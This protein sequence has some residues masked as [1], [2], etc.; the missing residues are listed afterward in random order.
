MDHVGVQERERLKRE[1]GAFLNAMTDKPYV[2]LR[3]MREHRWGGLRL[4]PKWKAMRKIWYE[5]DEGKRK[6]GREEEEYFAPPRSPKRF[7]LGATGLEI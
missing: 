5:G 6:E 3:K 2:G 4:W 1:M 7:N